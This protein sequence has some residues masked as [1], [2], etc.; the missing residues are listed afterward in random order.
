MAIFSISGH[1]ICKQPMAISKDKNWYIE[2]P[3]K[4][5]W[6]DHL[7]YNR[8]KNKIEANRIAD[9]HDDQLLG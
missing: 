4:I 2:G 9:S 1:Y 5:G 8:W 3:K 6:R 7:R